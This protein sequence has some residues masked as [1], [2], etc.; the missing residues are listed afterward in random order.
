M[1]GLSKEN[2]LGGSTR[3]PTGV[4]G[5]LRPWIGQYGGREGRRGDRD[6]LRRPEE[7]SPSRLSTASGHTPGRNCF[8]LLSGWLREY[9]ATDGALKSAQTEKLTWTD[10]VTMRTTAAVRRCSSNKRGTRLIVA[11]GQANLAGALCDTRRDVFGPI[12]YIVFQMKMYYLFKNVLLSG[13]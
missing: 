5:S 7:I 8:K 4:R 10:P 13:I 6:T 11:T 3:V 2:L 9:L 12:F 1:P